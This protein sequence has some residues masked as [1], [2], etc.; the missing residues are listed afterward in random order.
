MTDMVATNLATTNISFK[1]FKQ[2][3]QLAKGSRFSLICL[4]LL[5]AIETA[6]AVYIPII[7]MQITDAAVG[8]ASIFEL[9]QIALLLLIVR[10]SSTLIG[11]SKG[12]LGFSI[13]KK[14]N[15]KI[16]QRIFSHIE[17]LSQQFFVGDGASS[18]I[19]A[20]QWDVPVISAAY[21]TSV[22]SLFESILQVSMTIPT[23]FI[24]TPDIAI[25]VVAMIPVYLCL[26]KAF[27]KKVSLLTKIQVLYRDHLSGYLN[28]KFSTLS[29]RNTKV[30]G[31]EEKEEKIFTKA[32]KDCL[33][34]TNKRNTNMNLAWA[35]TD[36]F[37]M[38]TLTV[39]LLLSCILIT[40]GKMT[41]GTTLAIASYMTTF[42]TS[43]SKMS[44]FVMEIINSFESGIKILDIFATKTNVPES[45]NAIDIRK[46][47]A[48]NGVDIVFE[49]VSLVFPE[50]EDI[51]Q[52][53]YEENSMNTGFKKNKKVLSD[54]NLT[55]KQGEKVGIV[56]PS[57]SGKS[58][59][60]NLI[61][62]F[63]DPTSGSV[64]ISGSD[65]RTISHSSLTKTVGYVAQESYMLNDTLRNNFL[66]I[67]PDATEEMMEEALAKADLL[68]IVQNM[69]QG[70]DTPAG[71]GG[72]ML[73]G[74]Q[75]QRFSIARIFLTSPDIII[76]DEATA[77]LDE[78]S[79]SAV[80]ATILS[81]FAD[82][83]IISV[84]HRMKALE[85]YDR[86]IT[87]R[88]GKIV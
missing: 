9:I 73:S 67:V 40:S 61:A 18:A 31:L 13:V 21:T 55:I 58:T 62:R 84:A 45:A 83:T 88:D 63:Y 66:H 60:A 53:R 36:F 54:I 70:L 82:K 46:Q 38:I 39:V 25:I 23:M 41:V 19:G 50:T 43:I 12:Q 48:N 8:G 56:G 34:T 16:G 42:Y 4:Y 76:F 27:N 11:F 33:N 69:P 28:E 7:V 10:M 64:T 86:V 26:P 65:I 85:G 87:L 79:E 15:L 57:G 51:L 37:T 75:R 5:V 49:N 72:S 2:Y 44:R 77:S 71:L 1:F 74:G 80:A 20:I 32:I 30:F 6:A 24:L 68:H 17:R 81:A 3:L 59:L 35:S 52:S 78:K 47:I 29:A 22:A 14:M